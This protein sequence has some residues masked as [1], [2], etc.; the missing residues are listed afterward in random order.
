MAYGFQPR[1]VLIL[2]G[3]FESRIMTLANLAGLHFNDQQEAAKKRIQKL[4][5]A[6]VVGERPRRP[7][8]PSILFLTKKGFDALTRENGLDGF[9]RLGWASLR[10]RARVSDLTLRH[11]LDV[12]AVK[13]ALVRA[14]RATPSF[15]VSE[16]STWPL[17]YQFEARPFGRGRT[18]LTKPDGFIRIEEAEA[19][20]NRSEHTFFLEVDRS[21]E[22]QTRLLDRAGCY[23][24]FYRAGG[25]A[26]RNG[27]SD[28]AYKDFP[29]RVLMVFKTAARRDN[30]ART[31]F[32]NNPPIRTQV[33]LTTL[34]Q[35]TND[36][37]GAIWLQPIQYDRIAW[38]MGIAGLSQANLTKKCLLA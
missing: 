36:P 2:R 13:T 8:H 37:L 3:L 5:A 25:L 20:G 24:D 28:S 15:T 21:T 7:Y 10:K 27:Q 19:D 22:T 35:F 12:M 32:E 26:I 4:K 9:P 30:T 1:D 38:G 11:E 23:M 17:L 33:W 14:V 16:F 6:G 31:L 18:V 29:F 34:T